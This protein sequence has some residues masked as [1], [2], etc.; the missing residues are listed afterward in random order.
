MTTSGFPGALD[1][2]PVNRQDDTD[3]KS[4]ADLGLTTTTGVHADDHNWVNDAVNKMQAELGINPR[5]L[6]AATVRERF[7]IAA[8]KNQSVRAASTAN[9][10]G[11]YANGTAGVGAT[12]AVGGTTLSVDGIA[13]ANGDRVLL[14]D[15]T[16]A[17]ENGIYTVS[18]IG[19]SVVLTRAIDADTATKIAD[20]RVLVDQGSQQGDTEWGCVATA[21][22]MGTTALGFKRT[23]PIYGHGNPRFPW[24]FG[25][26]LTALP[27]M[28]TLPRVLVSTAFTWALSGQTLVGGI[29]VPA[30]KTVTNINYVATTA[31]A[32]PSVDWFA[33][34]RQSDR[35]VQAH[36]A[37][38]VAAPTAGA[39]T[40]RAL[41]APWTP[42]Y[43]TP[44]WIVHSLVVATTARVVMAGPAGLAAANLLAP[45]ICA[46]NGVTPTTTLPTDGTTA[47]TAATTG[48]A[49][50]PY[51]WLT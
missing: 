29:V 28:A 4:G 1:T 6:Y 12:K 17:F 18:G 40:T 14:K 48:V 22:T 31:G 36:T 11:T 50:I 7:E 24:E 38:S 41:T 2:L 44:V 15:Q 3:S 9:V 30:G 26:S 35:I 13:M 42:N 33:L 27:I 23:S 43:D 45:A 21:P 37:N 20:C 39:I 47:I 34:A 10:T 46:S 25:A 51:F 8:Y 16:S 49:N 19:S 32:A 5:G